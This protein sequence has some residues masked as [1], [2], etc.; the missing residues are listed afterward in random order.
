MLAHL[1]LLATSANP[2]VFVM[3]RKKADADAAGVPYSFTT[4]LDLGYTTYDCDHVASADG[5][6]VCSRTPLACLPYLSDVSAVDDDDLPVPIQTVAESRLLR[7]TTD[8]ISSTI[9]IKIT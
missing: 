3:F 9:P 2:E 4:T 5:T 6:I 8:R 7:M 1:L